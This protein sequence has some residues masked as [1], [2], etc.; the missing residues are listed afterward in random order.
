[1]QNT[2]YRVYYNTKHKYK[3]H[4]QIHHI[5]SSLISHSRAGGSGVGF[6]KQCWHANAKIKYWIRLEKTQVQIWIKNIIFDWQIIHLFNYPT[7]QVKHVSHLFQLFPENVDCEKDLSRGMD[8]PGDITISGE[9]S[10][11]GDKRNINVIETCPTCSSCDEEKTKTKT[12][13]RK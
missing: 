11:E 9:R 2:K 5:P 8:S 1:M 13:T 10:L 4:K 7:S 6:I 12:K 3:F